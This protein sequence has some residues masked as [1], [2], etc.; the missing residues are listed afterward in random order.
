MLPREEG[1]K[2]SSEWPQL[3]QMNKGELPRSDHL[4]CDLYPCRG[5]VCVPKATPATSAIV[6]KH[7]RSFLPASYLHSILLCKGFSIIPVNLCYLKP[8][9][10]Y[11]TTY[12]VK[13]KKWEMDFKESTV[14]K[15]SSQFMSPNTQFSHSILQLLQYHQVTLHHK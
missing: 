11:K 3:L 15:H 1:V 9:P 2:K 6:R 4:Q 8:F 5:F 10:S 14:F 7:R 12:R 13:I